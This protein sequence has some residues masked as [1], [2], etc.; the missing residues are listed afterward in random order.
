MMRAVPTLLALPACLAVFVASSAPV[1]AETYYQFQSPSGNVGCAMGSLGNKA[2][3]SCEV[4]DRTWEAPPRPDRC[5]GAWGDRIT[6]YQG[7]PPNLVCSSD[8]LRSS[9]FPTLRYGN[10][11]PV[12]PI[13]CVSEPTGIACTDAVTGHYFRMSRDSYELH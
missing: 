2:F 6:L 9:D 10:A 12:N 5:E 1:R 3:A 4:T 8:S 11:W 7:T 13:S